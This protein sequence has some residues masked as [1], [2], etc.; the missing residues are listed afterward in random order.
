MKLFF[1]ATLKHGNMDYWSLIAPQPGRWQTLN[2]EP[3][4]KANWV[5]SQPPT[6]S[7]RYRE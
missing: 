6:P 4:E 7:F 1:I 2:G 3:L 5:R